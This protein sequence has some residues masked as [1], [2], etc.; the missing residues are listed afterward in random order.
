VRIEFFG[1]EIELLRM[2][3]VESQKS[4]KDVDDIT[5]FPAPGA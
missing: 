4:V 5:I 2:F 1:D 3:D